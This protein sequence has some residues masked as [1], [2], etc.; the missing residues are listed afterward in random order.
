MD[1]GLW[2]VGFEW[3]ETSWEETNYKTKKPLKGQIPKDLWVPGIQC[4]SQI[5]ND[6]MR[7][8]WASFSK[9]KFWSQKNLSF[10][11][12]LALFICRSL[13]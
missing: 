3:V 11:K 4:S 8:Q 9:I 6:K 7:I 10:N 2:E 5:M 12:V 1:K 13:L